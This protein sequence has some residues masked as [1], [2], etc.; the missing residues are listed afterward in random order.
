[1]LAA[2]V[3]GDYAR[4]RSRL[5]RVRLFY[6]A[7]ELNR[8]DDR[9]RDE[10]VAARHTPH[11]SFEGRL[12]AIHL[13]VLQATQQHQ[14]RLLAVPQSDLKVQ[15]AGLARRADL[16]HLLDPGE[17]ELE[18]LLEQQRWHGPLAAARKVVQGEQFENLVDRLALVARGDTVGQARH[19]GGRVRRR[20]THAAKSVGGPALE[21]GR[22]L[23][24]FSQVRLGLKGQ[25]V[26]IDVAGHPGQ[27]L[28]VLRL[29]AFGNAQGDERFFGVELDGAKVLQQD[30][31]AD[32]AGEG[33]RF[34]LGE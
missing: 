14:R 9:R 21:P 18:G 16:G 11:K 23:A 7:A 28:I 5:N 10:F 29:V 8:V 17:I 22:R 12:P 24:E 1:R 13:K 32:G 6:L 3:R 26:D 20:E 31:G 30:K 15:A 25:H 34:A 33:G 4:A 2:S 19:S 27:H